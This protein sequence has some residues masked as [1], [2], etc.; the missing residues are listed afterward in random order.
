MGRKQGADFSHVSRAWL[1]PGQEPV[2]VELLADPLLHQVMRRDGVSVTE[3]C[4]HIAAARS[5]LG[6]G[7]FGQGPCRCAA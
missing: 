1:D 6:L 2:L 3:L 4:N 7:D 5:R